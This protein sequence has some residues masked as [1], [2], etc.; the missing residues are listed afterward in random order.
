MKLFGVHCFLGL[1]AALFLVFPPLGLGLL[2]VG[3]V[4]KILMR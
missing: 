3:V 1:C 2:V 4:V